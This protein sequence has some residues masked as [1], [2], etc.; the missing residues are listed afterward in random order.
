ME[1]INRANFNGLTPGAYRSDIPKEVR[2][3][4]DLLRAEL[5]T[6]GSYP[7]A[8][9]LEYGTPT[10]KKVPG[11]V[12]PHYQW[13]W[14]ENLVRRVRDAKFSE[15]RH[16]AL[17][18]LERQWFTVRATSVPRNQW[19]IVK[20]LAVESE[21]LWRLRMPE[22]VEYPGDVYHVQTSFGG[23]PLFM[24]KPNEEATRAIIAEVKSDRRLME[25]TPRQREEYFEAKRRAIEEREKSKA[26]QDV[27]G[28]IDAR[29]PV[30]PHM[31]GKRNAGVW[32]RNASEE[33]MI[34]G[35]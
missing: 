10:F 11:S 30:R 14:S 16:G 35:T 28:W 7:V 33:I 26:R 13:M 24:Q 19:L 25:M 9:D 8:F 15:V 4:N 6:F 29:L 20:A 3:C 23:R 22:E 21:A 32:H 34:T 31:P 17:V 27:M 12:V 2:K 18:T 5:G 1:I